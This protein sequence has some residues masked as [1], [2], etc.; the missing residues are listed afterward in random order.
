M[1]TARVIVLWIHLAAVVVW[2]GGLIAVPFIAGPVVR[3]TAG[4]AAMEVLVRRFQRL[5][6]ELVFV[7]VLTGIFNLIFVG[8]LT[9]FAYAP[10]YL[11]LVAVKFALLLIMFGNQLWY[12]YR[13]FPEWV[14]K[15]SGARPTSLSAITNVVLG[16]I[17]LFLGLSL[18]MS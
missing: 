15:E 12:S 9:R 4:L 7:I 1:L 3:R 2:L 6:R 18:R 13:L 17:A 5:S 10:E 16:G 11:M 8:V 14:A